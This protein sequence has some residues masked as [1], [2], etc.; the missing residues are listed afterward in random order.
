MSLY[1]GNQKVTP[2]VVYKDNK[3]QQFI[4]GDLTELTKTDFDGCEKIT[5][6]AF[7]DYESLQSVSIGDSIISIGE[8]AFA[9]CH[10]LNSISWEN[11]KDI[12]PYAFYVCKKISTING[13]SV[14]NFRRYCFYRV[15]IRYISWSPNL[16]RVEAAAFE[17]SNLGNLTFPASLEFIGGAAFANHSWSDEMGR[18]VTFLGQT[19]DLSGTYVFDYVQI[20][21]CRY[22]TK[23]PVLSSTQS[24]Q[25][26]PFGNYTKKCIVPDNLYDEW[27]NATNWASYTNVTFI[28]ASEA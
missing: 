10:N 1:L 9:R 18:T 5:K 13:S 8:S 22:C 4:R 17:Y 6:S 12:G 11:V 14:E 23:V 3:L 26:Q 21:D 28:K 2:T 7:T 15:P 27:I 25:W 24:I 19:P 20:L 16:K